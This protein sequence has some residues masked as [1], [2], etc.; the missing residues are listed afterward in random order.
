VPNDCLALII[1]K[2]SDTLKMLKNMS[3]VSRIQIANEGVPGQTERNLYIEGEKK[4]YEVAVKMVNEI[5]E[6]HK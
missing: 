6:K 4:G 1:G 2:N 3:N 5:V